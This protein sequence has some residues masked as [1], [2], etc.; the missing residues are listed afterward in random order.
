MFSLCQ[1]SQSVYLMTSLTCQM[2]NS[3]DHDQ[4]APLGSTS[5]L[6]CLFIPI[7]LNTKSKYN[8]S[9]I[10]YFLSQEQLLLS[11]LCP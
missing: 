7:C 3:M 10:A 8:M 6:H 5:G 11:S 1:T 2:T 4:S 9:V